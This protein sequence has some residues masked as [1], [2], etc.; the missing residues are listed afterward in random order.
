LQSFQEA[1]IPPIPPDLIEAL[2]EGRMPV[3][4]TFISYSNR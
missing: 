3:D 2:P 1:H 4:F